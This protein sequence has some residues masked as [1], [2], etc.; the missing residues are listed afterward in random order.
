MGTRNLTIV[1]KN[2]EYKVAQYG[3][4]DGY[5]S[6]LGVEILRF[7]KGINLDIFKQKIEEVSFYTS[8]EL[9]EINKLIEKNEKELPG[10]DFRVQYEHLS[11]DCSQRVLQLILFENLRKVQNSIDFAADS[12]FC[13]WAYVID[14]DTDTL[15]VYKGF[16]TTHLEE[17]DR[18]FFLDKKIDKYHPV[19]LIKSYDISNL[20][21]EDTFIKEC[22]GDEE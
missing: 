6:G 12:L 16:N 13:E 20:P 14:L 9:D 3:Q 4:W 1:S 5:P 8:E 2:G 18:F 17:G 10:Y 11:R 7:I 15:E 19:K 22:E 21:N